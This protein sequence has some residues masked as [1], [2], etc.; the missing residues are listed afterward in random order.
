[1]EMGEWEVGAKN[2]VPSAAL[3]QQQSLAAIEFHGT[4][5]FNSTNFILNSKFLIGFHPVNLAGNVKM[6]QHLF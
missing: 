2:S 6:H 5:I 3:P 4:L 1:M